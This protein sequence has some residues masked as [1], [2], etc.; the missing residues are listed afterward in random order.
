MT[1][2]VTAIATP[3]DALHRQARHRL[4]YPSEHVV[5]FLAA[6][7]LDPED[8]R[9]PEAVDIGCGSG[10]HSI[11]L[12]AFGYNAQA[13][14]VSEAAVYATR[15]RWDVPSKR[16]LCAPMTEL[17]YADGRF[18]VAVAFAVFYYGS[19]KDHTQAVAELHRVL[20]PGGRAFVCLRRSEDWRTSFVHG[21]V[22]RYVDAPESGMRMDFLTEYEVG[23]LY[24]AFSERQLEQTTTTRAGRTNADWLLSVT[25]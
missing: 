17:P 25:K 3:W 22:F 5:R 19:R 11:L 20:R 7:E 1:A 14:D 10:R 18:D 8:N 2:T 13:C 21:G 9:R 23:V 4:E 6:V 12:E 15:T 16:V 24:G